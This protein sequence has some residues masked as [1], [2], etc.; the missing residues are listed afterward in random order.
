MS[1]IFHPWDQ[2]IVTSLDSQWLGTIDNP[3]QIIHKIDE[4]ENI[5]IDDNDKLR[6]LN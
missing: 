5:S 4:L 2:W 6:M 1:I 3:K